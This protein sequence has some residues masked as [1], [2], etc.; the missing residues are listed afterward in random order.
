MPII[1]SSGGFN[2]HKSF[3]RVSNLLSYHQLNRN[4]SGADCN[5]IVGS[6]FNESRRIPIA[7]GSPVRVYHR[8]KRQEEGATGNESLP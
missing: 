6:H 4:A 5:G 2:M 3:G 7:K 1:L 8:A